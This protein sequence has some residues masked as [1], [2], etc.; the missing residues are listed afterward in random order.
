MNQQFSLLEEKGNYEKE[1]AELRTKQI[2]I[3]QGIY[4]K[5][6]V[7]SVLQFTDMI[8]NV[9]LA[10]ICASS[11]LSD[12]DIREL[13]ISSADISTDAFLHGII[14]NL[15]F[16]RT[17]TILEGLPDTKKAKTLAILPLCDRIIEYIK[18]LEEESQS[19]YW[20]NIDAWGWLGEGFTLVEDTIRNL[21]ECGKTATSISILHSYTRKDESRVTT[22]LVAETLIQNVDNKT[23]SALDT[24][25]IQELIKWLQE[26]NADRN[27]LILIEWKYLAFLREDEGYPPIT[28]WEELSSNPEHFIYILKIFTGKE[29]GTE[30]TDEDKSKMVQHCYHLLESWKR[31][32]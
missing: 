11:F 17:K 28:L 2:A 26:R 32:S 30:W 19:S 5:G 20:N 13:L 27:S 3:L 29:R 22:Q 18:G 6:G 14:R 8:E 16:D 25:D 15:S 21:N 9:R 12:T 4:D 7:K 23:I 10:G 1:E 24:Y 31:I